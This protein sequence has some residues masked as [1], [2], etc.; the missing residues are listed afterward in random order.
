MQALSA[1]PLQ[2]IGPILAD[3]TDPRFA[4]HF[5][6]A[7]TD[8]LVNTVRTSPLQASLDPQGWLAAE[9]TY[10]PCP[11]ARD[12]PVVVDCANR[13]QVQHLPV[14]QQV[15]SLARSLSKRVELSQL[16]RAIALGNPV[17]AKPLTRGKG[18]DHDAVGLLEVPH[19][20]GAP[21][22]VDRH[23][24]RD[25]RAHVVVDHVTTVGEIDLQH[26]LGTCNGAD[27]PE[28]QHSDHPA[29]PDDRPDP[30]HSTGI[31][32]SSG[33]RSALGKRRQGGMGSDDVGGATLHHIT[34]SEGRVC[35]RRDVCHRRE[36]C[37]RNGAR[38]H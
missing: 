5:H 31:S 35:P 21:E 23:L 18:K 29:N 3:Y 2:N 34:P 36:A 1:S 9:F 16:G 24:P 27:H 11:G 22:V 25:Y 10:R 6:D 19:V 12:L 32:E 37:S 38:H 28:G 7:R 17:G 13:V 33:T 26:L 4:F 15:E 8:V 30:T 20:D 14:P